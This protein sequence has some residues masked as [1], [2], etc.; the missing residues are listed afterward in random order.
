MAAA[1][2][3]VAFR[4]ALAAGVAIAACRDEVLFA[5]SNRCSAALGAARAGRERLRSPVRG[6]RSRPKRAGCALAGA[7]AAGVAALAVV[8]PAS[9][10][11]ERWETIQAL[12]R[13]AVEVTL[14]PNHP[15]L[16]V[17]DLRRRVADALRRDPVAPAVETQSPE[18]LHLIVA[19]RAYSS[20]ELRGF[21]LPLSQSYGIGPVRLVLERPAQVPGLAAPIVVPV[22]Q[23]ERQAKGPWRTSAA[24]VLELTDEVVA[25]FL[26]DYRLA[27][28]R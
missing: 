20:S 5:S 27:A 6:K 14:S 17:E 12:P 11:A 16:L 26:E 1:R 15:E 7:S 10:A 24:Q 19:V 2:V 25:A 4:I 3:A 18:R 28:R 9:D 23:A 8:A 13:V 21:Y 22:W